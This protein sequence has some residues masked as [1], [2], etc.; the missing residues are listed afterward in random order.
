MRQ[1]LPLIKTRKK[2]EKCINPISTVAR[3][4]AGKAGG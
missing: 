2:N 3:I 4:L 1:K